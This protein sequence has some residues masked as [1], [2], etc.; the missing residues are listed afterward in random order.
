MKRFKKALLWLRRMRYPG[1]IAYWE[2]RYASG[3][4]SGIGSSGVLA[5]YKAIVL[6]DFVGQHNIQSV[7]EFGCGDGKQLQRAKYPRYKGLD[8]AM[9]AVKRCRALFAGDLNKS[10]HHYRPGNFHPEDFQ[11]ELGLSLEVIF[12]L[13]E[14]ELYHLHLQHLFACAQRWV[15]IFSSNDDD[16]TGGVFPHLKP[17]RFLADIPE[18]WILCRQMPN[19]HADISFSSFFIFEKQ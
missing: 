7:I 15:I 17:R 19:P 8:V 11:A 6:N 9:S 4:H 2:K 3:R 18:N 12:H 5:E 16:R 1:S 10:F 14:E 13:T